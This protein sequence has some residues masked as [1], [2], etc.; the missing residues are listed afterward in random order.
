MKEMPVA[1]VAREVGEHDTR[2]WRVFKY[3]V[4]QSMKEIDLAHLKRVAIDETSS[5]R[6]HRYVTLFLDMDSKKVLFVV[7]GKGSE[8]LGIFKQFI[9]EREF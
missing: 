9:Q 5:R 7:E 3:Y 8:G 1:A 4:Q 6:G 2:L